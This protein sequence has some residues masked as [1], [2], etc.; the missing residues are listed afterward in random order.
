MIKTNLVYFR[1]QLYDFELNNWE[2]HDIIYLEWP[3]NSDYT[4]YSLSYRKL[5]IEL[6]IT[7]GNKITFFN[8]CSN[9]NDLKDCIARNNCIIIKRN[10]ISSELL[11]KCD[12]L[13]R[14][15]LDKGIKIN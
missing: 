11:K 3:N 7:G 15:K 10:D 8:S 5:N 13:L 4:K 1:G 12:N 6:E 14:E 9:I 2:N